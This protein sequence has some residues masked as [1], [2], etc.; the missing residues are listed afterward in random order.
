MAL[1]W[2]TLLKTVPWNDVIGA[3]PHLAG[4]AR[5][6]WDAVSNKPVVDSGA[7]EAPAPPQESPL[8]AIAARLEKNDA[9]LAA[10]HGQ[11]LAASEMIARLAEQNKGLVDKVQTMRVWSW[12]LT[13]ACAVLALAVVAL[14]IR[15]A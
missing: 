2:L 7:A 4:G 14:L 15:Q 3:A 10:L 6:L 5:K 12:S 13:G 1:P 11:M 8:D 9:A